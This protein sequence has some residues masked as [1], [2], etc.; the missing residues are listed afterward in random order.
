MAKAVP[1]DRHQLAD[2]YGS[3]EW[4]SKLID[5]TCLVALLRSSLIDRSYKPSEELNA[6]ILLSEAGKRVRTQLTTQEK[7]NAKDANVLTLLALVHVE[8]LLDIEA[9]D[10]EKLRQAISSE[11]RGKELRYPLI[12]GRHLY[13]RAAELFKQERS[14]LSYQDT[15]DLLDGSEQGVFQAGYFLAGP[16]GVFRRPYWRGLGPRTSIPLQHCADRSCNRVHSIQLATSQEAG[17]NKSR[18]ALSKVLDAVSDEPSEWNEFVRDFTEDR[19]NPYEVQDSSAITYV[20][21]DA[22]SDNE[23]RELAVH[24]LSVSGS[25]TK[26]AL[27]E[28]GV[29]GSPKTAIV[30]MTRAEVIQTLFMLDD[31]TLAANVDS[32]VLSGVIKVPSDEV[33]TP[34]VNDRSS[35]GAWRLKPQLSRLGVRAINRSSTLPLL[36]LAATARGLFSS[37]SADEMDELSWILR[38]VRGET[39]GE[40]LEEFLRTCEP[41][42]VVEMLILARR[43]NAT[44]VC[45]SLHIDLNQSNESLRDAILWKLGFPLPSSAD[46]RDEYWQLHHGL[47]ALAKSAAV[48]VASSA[49]VLRAAASDYFVSLERFL[50][51]SL[52][53]ATWALCED[54]FANENPFVFVESNARKF[55]IQYLNNAAKLK[56]KKGYLSDEPVLSEVVA[57][58]NDLSSNLSELRDDTGTFERNAASYPEFARRTDLQRFPFR[59]THPFLDL[60]AESQVTLI[61]SLARVSSDLNDSGIMTARN[62]LLHAKQRIPTVAEVKDAL[63]RARGALDLLETMGCVRSTFSLLTRQTTAWGASTTTLASNG[64]SITFSSPSSFEWARLPTLDKP[65]YLMQGAVFSAPNE[66]LRFREGFESEFNSYWSSFPIRPLRGSSN[67]SSGES[68]Q[69]ASVVE[70]GS[71]ESTRTP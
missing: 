71:F 49:E 8:P 43:S 5:A 28:L 32:A 51:D 20:I 15:I 26:G 12:Y 2:R 19:S 14:Y 57:S 11:V 31:E 35:T 48:D 53:F 63:R 47:E 9:I 21:G 40:Q 38:G 46:I 34:M 42:H 50:F 16:F 22:F 60:T 29:I 30:A 18:P 27:D 68:D 25:A 37:D 13:D 69:V 3:D 66:M 61:D 64:R 6:A 62:G 39:P 41:A 23:L 65:C 44:R 55:A 24:S 10:L 7:V 36:R 58:F 59:H 45:E 52:I 4:R 70:A 17:V 54:H 67:L 56:D 33:R 1:L